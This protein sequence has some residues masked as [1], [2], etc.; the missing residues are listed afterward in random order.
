M[1]R[2]EVLQ[3]DPT[4][5]HRTI[6]SA[7]DLDFPSHIVCVLTASMLRHLTARELNNARGGYG[8]FPH[9]GPLD[10]GTE[11]PEYP[12]STAHDDMIVCGAVS[13]HSRKAEF[14]IIYI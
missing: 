4:C 12:S 5:Q 1:R 13:H 9:P 11:S 14:D 10:R 8:M 6:D 2:H 3:R 7:I